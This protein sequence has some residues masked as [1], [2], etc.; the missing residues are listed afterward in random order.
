MR[1]GSRH[2][3]ATAGVLAVSCGDPVGPCGCSPPLP[4]G[5]IRGTVYD[6]AGRPIGG[7][8]IHVGP[9][10]GSECTS[11]NLY[12]ATRSG[13]DGR[14][15]AQYSTNGCRPPLVEAWAEPAVGSPWRTSLPVTFAT[16]ERIG[17]VTDT[18]FVELVLRDP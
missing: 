13:P 16:F 12:P 14:F 17:E 8:S 6:V 2:T 3:L 9:V 5:V 11:V 7:A 1:T 18:A 4:S 10:A 15:L